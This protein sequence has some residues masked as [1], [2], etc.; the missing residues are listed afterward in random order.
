MTDVGMIRCLRCRS[1]LVQASDP[2]LLVCGTC[3][4]RYRAVMTLVPVDSE[5]SELLLEGHAESGS[6]SR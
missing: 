3:G 1:W 4:R 2:T 6:G 5:E